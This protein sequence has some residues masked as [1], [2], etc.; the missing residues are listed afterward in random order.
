M[1]QQLLRKGETVAFVGLID[2]TYKITYDVPGELP[3]AKFKRHLGALPH[4]ALV[5]YVLHRLRRTVIH[6][7]RV[8][9]RTVAVSLNFPEQDTHVAA[10]AY[11]LCGA[12]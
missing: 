11:P 8:G 9:G 10:L 7:S 1:A 5:D 3:A 4:Q 6:Y 12:R 2:S